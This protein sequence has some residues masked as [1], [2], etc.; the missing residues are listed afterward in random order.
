M[1]HGDKVCNRVFLD[2]LC[3]SI[4][5]MTSFGNSKSFLFLDFHYPDFF[6]TF[7]N[8]IWKIKI[9]FKKVVWKMR[10]A[11][12]NFTQAKQFDKFLKTIL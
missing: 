8:G 2:Y 4:I 11:L 7:R 6:L 9:K 10:S 1:L 5:I 12:E 3:K